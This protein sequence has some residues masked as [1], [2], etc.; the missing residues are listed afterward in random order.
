MQKNVYSFEDGALEGFSSTPPG[1]FK[2]SRK[3]PRDGQHSLRWDYHKGA[4][5]ILDSPNPFRPFSPG[6]ANKAQDSFILYMYS[7]EKRKARLRFDFLKKGKRCC[8]FTVPVYF[9]GRRALWVPY[10]ES[11]EGTPE[12]GMD[13][14]EITAEAG[15]GSIWLDQMI[16]AVAVD[17]RHPTRDAQQ[18]FVNLRAD[19]SANAHWMSLYRFSLLENEAL[20]RSA[21]PISPEVR[22]RVTARLDAYFCEEAAKREKRSVESLKEDFLRYEIKEKDG[23]LEGRTIDTAVHRAAWPEPLYNELLALTRPIDV[24]ETAGL[25]LDLAYY[26]RGE[27]PRR[28]EAENYF[29]LLT[30]HMMDQGFAAGSGLGT[31]HHLGYPLRNYY[32][33]MFLHTTRAVGLN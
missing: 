24:K 21:A 22:E 11:M 28:E 15:S 18:P 33:A 12:A 1:Q 19:T 23:F 8:H 6:A 26:L 25:L 16:L 30:R 20:K 2:I 27:A 17:P 10:E 29:L 3:H 31:V 9:A 5:L 13:R 14:L 4:K 7:E 32:F